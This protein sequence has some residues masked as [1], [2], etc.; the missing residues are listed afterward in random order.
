M[1]RL[2]IL[3]VLCACGPD[4]VPAK[5]GDHPL[6]TGPTLEAPEF[7]VR[8]KRVGCSA[9]PEQNAWVL[10]CLEAANPKSDEEPED[11]IGECLYM[12]TMQFC[13]PVPAVLDVSEWLACADLPLNH[14]ARPSC[15]LVVWPGEV[16]KQK[17]PKAGEQDQAK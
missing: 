11:W 4:R 5:S 10:G 16:A 9:T 1:H 2:V 7:E 3:L 8:L 6:F 17:A 15:D 14:R 13:K 12:A